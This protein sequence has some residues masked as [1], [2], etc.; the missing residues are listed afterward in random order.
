MWE[1][2]P[3]VRIVAGGAFSYN[4]NCLRNRAGGVEVIFPESIEKVQSVDLFFDAKRLTFRNPEV[5][6]SGS[7]HYHDNVTLSFVTENGRSDIPLIYPKPTGNNPAYEKAHELYKRVLDGEFN[8]DI[9]DSE[10]LETGL[11]MNDLIDI[12]CKRLKGG[13]RLMDSNRTRYEDY[14]KL[15]MRRALSYAE[16]QGDEETAEFL[17]GLSGR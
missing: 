1:I 17:R 10:I 15:H 4:L 8:V 13:Y 6:I 3:D 5:R 7:K 14:L 2:S 16:A 12:A 9:Y 11:P